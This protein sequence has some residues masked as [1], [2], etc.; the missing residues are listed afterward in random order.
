MDGLALVLLG[1]AVTVLAFV[2]KAIFPRLSLPT[3]F[4]ISILIICGTFFVL[5]YIGSHVGA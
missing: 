5:A 1:V 4:A 2:L 3:C